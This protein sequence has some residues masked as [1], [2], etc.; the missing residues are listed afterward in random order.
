M[1]DEWEEPTFEGIDLPTPKKG[2]SGGEGQ[3]Q[4]RKADPKPGARWDRLRAV[5]KPKCGE[6]IRLM[7]EGGKW[8]APAPVV[9]T[10]TKGVDVSFWCYAHGA[11][12]RPLDGLEARPRL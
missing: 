7:Q 11:E 1:T 9:W 6:C 2:R 10:R 12:V 4:A 5:S 3:R 8:A